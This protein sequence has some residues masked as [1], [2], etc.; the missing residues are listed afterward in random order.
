MISLLVAGEEFQWPG[1]FPLY[2]NI[3][4]DRAHYR[5]VRNRA[6]ETSP[7]RL[8]QP[9]PVWLTISLLFY[10]EPQLGRSVFV[11]LSLPLLA[12]S[13]RLVPSPTDFGLNLL[14]LPLFSL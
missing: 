4:G 5:A 3:R 1:I 10:F 14:T 2:S 11:M 13:E 7:R 9:F 12:T 6:I 8:E